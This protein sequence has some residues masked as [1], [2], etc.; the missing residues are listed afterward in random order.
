MFHTS[1]SIATRTGPLGFQIQLPET[2]VPKTLTARQLASDSTPPLG[3]RAT[4]TRGSHGATATASLEFSRHGRGR[5]RRAD[6]KVVPWARIASPKDQSR[7]LQRQPWTCHMC[8][9]DSRSLGSHGTGAALYGCVEFCGNVP[10]SQRGDRDLGWRL[11][12]MRTGGGRKRVY[13]GETETDIGKGV[14]CCC[15]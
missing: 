6:T 8:R 7:A 5:S 3:A 10:G 4:P 15:M 9:R 12:A 2:A 13:L 11:G 1:S 14:A